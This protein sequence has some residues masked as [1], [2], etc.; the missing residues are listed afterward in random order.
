MFRKL[1]LT[2]SRGAETFFMPCE[3]QVQSVKVGQFING[4]NP[5]LKISPT[6][7]VGL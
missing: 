7:T 4:K 5:Q 2:F 6:T 1:F 3:S